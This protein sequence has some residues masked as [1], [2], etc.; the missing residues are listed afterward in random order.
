MG[1]LQHHQFAV[2][3]V[4]QIEL[5]QLVEKYP[6]GNSGISRRHANA[7]C[8]PQGTPSDVQILR[9]SHLFLGRELRRGSSLNM[10]NHCQDAD[11]PPTQSEKHL[12]E[13]WQLCHKDAIRNKE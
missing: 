8:L 12:T 13:A 10:P 4:L 9:R 5:D 1:Y 3:D 6:E 7:R 11:P 2:Q